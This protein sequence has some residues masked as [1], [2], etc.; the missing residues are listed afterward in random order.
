M[1]SS[2]H[3]EIQVTT[4]LLGSLGGGGKTPFLTTNTPFKIFLSSLP[5]LLIS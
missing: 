4:L 2:T 1:V 3:T 5:L